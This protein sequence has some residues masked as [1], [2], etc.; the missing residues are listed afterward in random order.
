MANTEAGAGRK[1]RRR[2][3]GRSSGG[4]SS[5]T[6]TR[7]YSTTGGENDYPDLN[8][9]VEGIATQESEHEPADQLPPM[10][11]TGGRSSKYER[12]HRLRLLHRMMMRRIPLEEVARELCVSVHTVMNDRKELY[13]RLRAEAQKLDINHLIGDTLGFY[14]EVQG[15]SLRTAS[16][17][18]TPT[19]IK[20]AALRTALSAKNDMHRFLNLS[21][22]YDV[23]RYRAADDGAGDDI[24]KLM[25]VTQALL[26]SDSELEKAGADMQQDMLGITFSD[27]DE[28]IELL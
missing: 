10:Q 12:E 15:M 13:R 14:G 6:E 18:K 17:P 19:N 16:I 24:S 25:E 1:V 28:E 23:L 2:V 20:L 9:A 5:A 22:V 11:D 7:S 27:E 21:G 26:D 8:S 4:M 3:R